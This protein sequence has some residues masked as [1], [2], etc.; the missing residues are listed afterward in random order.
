MNC[1]P[2]RAPGGI[3]RVPRPGLV[4]HETTEL[5]ASEMV[6]LRFW[7]AQR[8]KSTEMGRKREADYILLVHTIRA[9][10]EGRLAKGVGA[11]SG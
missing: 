4:H 3:R 10:D 5:S 1:T 6:E 8:Q 11:F 2:C 9:I 7:G